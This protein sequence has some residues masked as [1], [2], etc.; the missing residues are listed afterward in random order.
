MLFE[1]D[2]N[3]GS[4][5]IVLADGEHDLGDDLAGTLAWLFGAHAD[6]ARLSGSRRLRILI[7]DLDARGPVR[8]YRLDGDGV[9]TEMVRLLQAVRALP[10]GIE[11]LERARNSWQHVSW[12]AIQQARTAHLLA[13]AHEIA[14]AN[15]LAQDRRAA[16]DHTEKD[17]A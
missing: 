2:D 8:S 9:D 14:L 13:S 1:V 6:G 15:K 10:Y 4:S 5:A 12:Q 11:L 3:D 16:R 7:E 17:T